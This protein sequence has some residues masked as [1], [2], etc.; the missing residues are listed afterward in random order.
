MIFLLIATLAVFV[1]PF[2][3]P[4]YTI[5]YLRSYRRDVIEQNFGCGHSV[6]YGTYLHPMGL[7]DA[8]YMLANSHVYN[9][10]SN[11][12]RKHTFVKLFGWA[13][14]YEQLSTNTAQVAEVIANSLN[15]VGSREIIIDWKYP[16]NGGDKGFKLLE[17]LATGLQKKAFTVYVKAPASYFCQNAGGKKYILDLPVDNFIV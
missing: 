14:D 7:V 5:H 17:E 12:Q 11:C 6:V 15:R 10:N 16:A 2:P 3:D 4:T 13:Q 9:F 8:L 1:S